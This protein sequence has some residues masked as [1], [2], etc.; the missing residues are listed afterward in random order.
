VVLPVVTGFLIVALISEADHDDW[1]GTLV[2]VVFIGA[3]SIALAA[4]GVFFFTRQALERL[5]PGNWYPR[6]RGSRLDERASIDPEVPEGALISAPRG[7]AALYART[8]VFLVLGVAAAALAVCIPGPDDSPDERDWG[9]TVVM[10]LAAAL[11]VGMGAVLLPL[12][13]PRLVRRDLDAIDVGV[14]RSGVVVRGGLE[15]DWRDIAE[16]LV[17]R[18]ERMTSYI[19]SRKNRFVIEPRVAISPT[20][21]PGHSRTRL[22]LVLHDLPGIVAR[23]PRSAPL[24]ADQSKSYGYALCDLWTYSREEVDDV[25]DAMRP[26]ARRAHVRVTELQRVVG[27]QR[28]D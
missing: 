18:D 20:Y 13:V 25:I 26:I 15:L 17:V 12:A 19:G 21:F 8:I 16:V 23:A 24:Y 3:G 6:L 14:M 27:V 28:F 2:L 4:I 1:L 9:Y 11:A 7:H 5:K 10:A 22:A